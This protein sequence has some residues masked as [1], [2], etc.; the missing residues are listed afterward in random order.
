M[1]SMGLLTPEQAK[2]DP[3]RHVIT[4][5]LGMPSE[6]RVSPYYAPT[7]QVAENDVY[8]LCSDGLSDMVEDAQMEA[9]L[10]KKADPQEAASELV[11]TALENGGRDN[12]TVMVVKIV[13]GTDEKKDTAN[14]SSDRKLAVKILQ[15]ITGAGFVA[16]LSDFI[17]YLMK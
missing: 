13:A 8:L 10:R 11:K 12:V 3:S 15:A 9:I 17:Y 16:V 7:D 6:I 5:Y 4:Q 2:K 1:I 14:K